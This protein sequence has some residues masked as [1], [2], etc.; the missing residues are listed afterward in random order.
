MAWWQYGIQGRT[1]SIATS[2]QVTSPVPGVANLVG[3]APSGSYSLNPNPTAGESHNVLLLTTEGGTQIFLN[4]TPRLV[5]N[6][7]LFNPSETRNVWVFSA[8]ILLRKNGTTWE[9]TAPNDGPCT[10][11][12]AGGD[13]IYEYCYRVSSPNGLFSQDGYIYQPMYAFPRGKNGAGATCPLGVISHSGGIDVYAVGFSCVTYTDHIEIPNPCKFLGSI[14]ASILNNPFWFDPDTDA[15]SEDA[16]NQII[17]GGGEVVPGDRPVD[18]EY[19]GDDMDFPDLPTGAS[20]LGFGSMKIFH[21]NSTQLHNA[22][23]ILWSDS[24]ETTLESI[25][26]SCKKW[27]YKPEQYCVSLNLMPVDAAGTNSR[28]YFGKYDTQVDAPAISNQYLIVDCGSVQ[29]P[30]KSGSAFD[31][32]DYVKVSLF[33]PY[34]GFRQINTNEIMGGTVSI[35]YYVDMFTGVSLCNVL[36][37]NSNCNTAILYTYECNISQQIPITSENYNTVINALLSASISV[38]SQNYGS[39]IMQGASAIQN[40]GS[41][42]IQTSGKMN[43]NAGALG[44]EK[45][46]IILHFPVQSLPNGF[47][48]QQGYPA[49]SNVLLGNLSGYVEVEKVHLDISG[50]Y[51]EDIQSIQRSLMEGVIL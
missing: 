19:E 30:L 49:S 9:T 22:L 37:S 12:I 6:V 51:D 18:Y 21:P 46:Y 41:P 20:A 47:D 29:V 10:T 16:Y 15:L 38:A 33:L 27:W 23:D 44:Y 17:G 2:G 48:S 3:F 14:P 7:T 50:A 1:E 28:I 26:E 43:S 45:P 8:H 35:K 36:V 4:L 32:G 31:Y 5:T 11:I 42:A 40:V 34:I 13:S 25:I 24:T 39:A